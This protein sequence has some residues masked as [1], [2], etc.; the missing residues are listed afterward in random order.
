[1]KPFNVFPYD[2][3]I[4]FM[5]MRWVSLSVALLLMLVAIAHQSL[6]AHRLPGEDT[7]HDQSHADRRAN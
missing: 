5:R 7:A 6:R 1:M 4:D 2:S 3:N